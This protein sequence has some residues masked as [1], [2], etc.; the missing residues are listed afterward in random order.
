MLKESRKN[1]VKGL[2]VLR[3]DD[4]S[5]ERRTADNYITIAHN[6]QGYHAYNEFGKDGIVVKQYG[7]NKYIRVE[8]NKALQLHSGDEIYFEMDTNKAIGIECGGKKYSFIRM[9]RFME[10]KA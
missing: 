6:E 10:E 7:T 2:Y 9:A 3:F 4:P 1:L 5:K 8:K